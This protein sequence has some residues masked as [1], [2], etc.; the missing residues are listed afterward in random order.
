MSDAPDA[1]VYN[2]TLDRIIDGDTLDCILDLGFD[3]KLHKQRVRLAGID[4]PES[5][6][7][8]KAEKV[9]GLQAKERL[10]ELCCGKFK[11]KSLGKGKY[12]RILG[13]P[14][15]EDGEDICQ[16]LIKEKHAVEYW[17]GTKTGRIT[18]DGT[19]GE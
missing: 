14:Y 16:M 10:K 9:L 18:E 12:G 3:V 5:R 19:W 6:T 2:A 15:T 8:N 1:F 7:R 11:I 17:G 4:T 13:I